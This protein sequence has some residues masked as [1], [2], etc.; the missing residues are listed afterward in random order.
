MKLL[1]FLSAFFLVS[2]QG[3]YSQDYVY[4]GNTNLIGAGT[5]KGDKKEGVWKIYQKKEVDP[6]P[7]EA[8]SALSAAAVALD[9]DLKTP[10][11]RIEFRNNLPDGTFEAFFPGG[12]LKKIA[13][14]VAGDLNGDFF[15]FSEAGEVVFSGT[16]I[17]SKRSGDWLV[18]NVD[19]RKKSAY[20][21]ENDLLQG[22]SITYYPSGQEAERIPFDQGKLN[23]TYQSFF[24]D[25]SL[26]KSVTF[27]ENLEQGEFKNF[28]QDGKPSILCAYSKGLLEG[29]WQS[30]DEKGI[31]L[32]E[33]TYQVGERAG[34]WKEIYGDIPGFYTRGTYDA[35]KKI[36]AWQLLGVN[37][38]VHQEEVFR[39]GG[40]VAISP[41][42]TQSG[43][44][45]DAGDMAKGDGK[46]T[47][48][49]MEGNRLEKGR[50]ANGLRTGTWFSYF[51]QNSL[52]AT[53][54]SYVAGQKRGS[55]K[56]YD[57]S[58]QL[59]SEEVIASGQAVDP[60]R[61][62]DPMAS[63]QSRSR[64]YRPTEPKGGMVNPQFLIST[65]DG[66][67]GIAGPGMFQVRN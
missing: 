61:T 13:Q 3:V 5:L 63:T 58:G 17:D 11:F 43:L 22:L 4:F 6:T 9:F 49:D 14:Y 56:Q 25:G 42:T 44:V 24:P 20:T 64:F 10:V 47:I 60:Q 39:Q 50:Y 19:G 2:F 1:L 36:G 52:V 27:V 41:F 53:S 12:N 51:P 21:Y 35:G 55:W 32:A 23:G 31:L 16:Y 66:G 33:G 40:L 18:F 46:R 7:R 34:Q 65:P 59:V 37:D 15:E 8:M 67:G 54:G 45:L 29:P 57:F 26:Q 48:Y 62:A 30:F 38:F 28:Y